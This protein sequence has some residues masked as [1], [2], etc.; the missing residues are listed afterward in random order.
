MTRQPGVRL[1]A[2]RA[3]SFACLTWRQEPV[4]FDMK[5]GNRKHADSFRTHQCDIRLC[6]R[7]FPTLQ[8]KGRTVQLD[9][10]QMN[11]CS[12]HRLPLSLPLVMLFVVMGLA[13]GPHND[14]RPVATPVSSATPVSNLALAQAEEP[15]PSQTA[16]PTP[17]QTAAP[18]SMAHLVRTTSF[19]WPYNGRVTSYFGPGHPLGIDIA[20]DP[21]EV[22][23]IRASGSGTV[24]F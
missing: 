20:I 19:I 5:V 2:N 16:A 3:A 15:T 11:N 17:S 13:C 18:S 10:L 22:A 4:A 1:T 23:P 7:V 6:H 21:G 24:E 12:G 9:L 14:G 8:S